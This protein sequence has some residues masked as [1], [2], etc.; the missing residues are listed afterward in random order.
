MGGTEQN[1]TFEIADSSVVDSLDIN[2]TLNR[3]Y[4]SGGYIFC[5]DSLSGSCIWKVPEGYE[6]VS[7]QAQVIITPYFKGNIRTTWWYSGFKS[8][9][10]SIIASPE[11]S[12]LLWTNP[13]LVNNIPTGG[14]AQI[15]GL[16]SKYDHHGV[17][18][19]VISYTQYSKR[20]DFWNFSLAQG[21]SYSKREG[22]V[23]SAPEK[24]YEFVTTTGFYYPIAVENLNILIDGANKPHISWTLRNNY[25]GSDVDLD[26]HGFYYS[27]KENNEWNNEKISVSNEIYEAHIA[28]DNEDNVYLIW[29][30]RENPEGG[31]FSL[32]YTKKIKDNS[33]SDVKNVFDS[34]IVFSNLFDLVITD[35]GNAHI[36]YSKFDSDIW[37]VWHAIMSQSGEIFSDTIF[38]VPEFSFGFNILAEGDDLHSIFLAD[39]MSDQCSIGLDS[40]PT[41]LDY[42]Y[43]DGNTKNWS[44]PK[45][46]SSEQSGIFI[47]EARLVKSK[48]GVLHIIYSRFRWN[49]SYKEEA[50]TLGW[51]A[52]GKD[53]LVKN[54]ATI[55]FKNYSI[56][57]PVLNYDQANDRLSLVWLS[58]YLGGETKVFY[59]ETAAVSDTTAPVITLNGSAE[60]TIT[61][62]E[63]YTELGATAVDAV[64]GSVAVVMTGSVDINTV[65]DY[66]ITYTATDA[67]GNTTTA[68]RTVHVAAAPDNLPPAVTGLTGH[69]SYRQI[70]LSWQA[71][72]DPTVFDY[73]VQVKWPGFD[74]FIL[75]KGMVTTTPVT[76]IGMV[77]NVNC[78]IRVAAVNSYGVGPYS[79]IIEIFT[80]P[81]PLVLFNGDNGLEG[82]NQGSGTVAIVDDDA[83]HG[84][85]AELKGN[86]M[87][88]AYFLY[89]T[90]GNYNNQPWMA[91]DPFVE[92]DMKYSEDYA[93]MFYVETADKPY[94]IKYSPTLPSGK[95][96]NYAT[97]NLGAGTKDGNWRKVY[98]NLQDDIN[99]QFPNAHIEATS[100]AVFYGSGRIDNVKV[101]LSAP[102]ETGEIAGTVK[103]PSGNL[104]SGVRVTLLPNNITYTTDVSGIFAFSSLPYGN[105]Q[106]KAEKLDWEFTEQAVSIDSNSAFAVNLVG[107]VNYKPNI[108]FNGEPGA[109]A[110]W[111]FT[112][113]ASVAI[114]YE[115][116]EHGNVA[117]LS[118][119]GMYSD[120][121]LS[122]DNKQSWNISHRYVSWEM[123]YSENYI[124]FIHVQTDKG[125][126]YLRYSPTTNP[127]KY[128]N[129][130]LLKLE[131][132]TMGG[133]WVKVTRDIQADMNTQFPDLKITNIYYAIV[134]GSGKIDNVQ[135]MKELN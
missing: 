2:F 12:N 122:T 107:T 110:G 67:A 56:N 3:N 9:K 81:Q 51:L 134:Y 117:V 98:R 55:N 120:Y 77:P 100:H 109:S 124:I 33:W 97:I 5:P 45:I 20:D 113:N 69:V 75:N 96:G 76:V 22:G 63:S 57:S 116:P 103:D 23:W 125:G 64:D 73:Y 129:Y 85:V 66:I 44:E 19:A 90:Q 88:T 11:Q 87:S 36:I 41:T 15:T 61:V 111:T 82:W 48:D 29:S 62:G 7:D 6:N 123:K 94:Y 108:I 70:A 131:G 37:H 114:Q 39:D 65:G 126:Y 133:S 121:V 1:L 42:M 49:D 13:E 86:G 43:F 118:G 128:E 18:H 83:E 58:P 27:T 21:V 52:V 60:M 14:N 38:S 102:Y 40:C 130:A 71:S 112:P 106:L 91:T 50:G 24:V 30:S 115:D 80:E 92:W 10:F 53:K 119:N 26:K 79:D 84:K 72:S 32:Y 59:S 8:E 25:S 17:L 31:E 135:T 101:L 78:Q 132:D 47:Y 4:Y 16:D 68:D 35:N 127:G 28:M 34:Q 93:I 54:L 89:R 74:D 95:S 105:Y 99:T 104:M 46:L